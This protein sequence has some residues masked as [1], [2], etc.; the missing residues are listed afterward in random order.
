MR[1]AGIVR[2]LVFLA[3]ALVFSGCSGNVSDG[4]SAGRSSLAYRN[5]RSYYGVGMTNKNDGDLVYIGSDGAIENVTGSLANG[6]VIV[7][8]F[9]TASPGRDKS[10]TIK[11]K[12]ATCSAGYDVY[13]IGNVNASGS[14]VVGDDMMYDVDISNGAGTIRSRIYFSYGG[15]LAGESIDG[16]MEFSLD[17]GSSGT[18]LIRVGSGDLTRIMVPDGEGGFGRRHP[19]FDGIGKPKTGRYYVSREKGGSNSQHPGKHM[20]VRFNETY[21]MSVWFSS[22]NVPDAAAEPDDIVGNSDLHFG[23]AGLCYDGS[24]A[25]NQ[26]DLTMRESSSS[27]DWSVIVLSSKPHAAS[28]WKGYGYTLELTE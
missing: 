27:S 1:K 6:G 23:P 24:P 22:S 19:K 11:Y 28:S 12:D 14:F 7:T 2:L 4:G 16:D 10:M 5:Y 21:D 8:G 18:T 13:S 3:G 17:I 20:I 9:D 26:H 15:Y 25:G